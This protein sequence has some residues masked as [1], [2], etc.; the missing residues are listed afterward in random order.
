VQGKR[1]LA[2]IVLATTSV[3]L[4]IAGATHRTFGA[5][6]IPTAAAA[7]SKS[8]CLTLSR[9]AAGDAPRCVS[10]RWY[11]ATSAWNTP[12]P[13]SVPIHPNTAEMIDA[14]QR[15]YCPGNGCLAPTDEHS[16]PSAWIATKSTP[17][18]T[19]Q[20][21]RPGRCDSDRVRAPIPSGAIPSNA[22]DP[23]PVM[24][25]MQRDSGEEWDFFKVTPPGMERTSYDGCATNSRW[26]A[27]IAAHHRPG[28]TGF[29]SRRS[30]RAS[31][32][33]L[34]TG[35][36]RPR[37]W[38]MPSGKTWDHALALAYPGTRPA[39]AYP[40]LSSDGR[41]QSSTAC[42][43]EGARLRLDPSVKCATWPGLASE[44]L[45]Q[46]CRTLQKF[47]MIVVDSGKGLVAENSVSA[48]TRNRSADP[49]HNGKIPPW[50][51]APESQY[52]PQDLVARL[53]V[54]DWTR[55]TGRPRRKLMLEISGACGASRSSQR[56]R[57]EA[58]ARRTNGLLSRPHVLGVTP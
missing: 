13:E 10:A 22:G 53:R 57:E 45:R 11:R 50:K 48:E 31:G 41:C 6:S 38:Q 20:I 54:I 37:D 26:Q 47:G 3:G 28:W 24:A 55:W 7:T 56:S 15:I 58:P 17:L 2:G 9:R 8:S 40:A 35:M 43:P 52:L 25:V 29:G 33:L 21:N 39:H 4:P 32:T 46:M 51:R 44:F 18:V 49:P 34:G 42:L 14:M 19:V 30:T 12:V 23:E 27:T 16:T 1:A 5:T 36:L